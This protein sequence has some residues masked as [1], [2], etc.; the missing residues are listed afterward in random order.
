MK[1]TQPLPVEPAVA[2]TDQLDRHGV[3][4]RVAGELA[5]RELGQLAVVAARQVLAHVAD[6]ARRPGGSCRAAILPPG[7][8]T[9]P[10]GRPRPARGRPRAARARCPRSGGTRPARCGR[11]WDRWSG[12]PPA[13][14]P[15]PRAARCSSSSS[16]SGF[17]GVRRRR[18][19]R[20][21]ISESKAELTRPTRDRAGL[22]PRA[23]TRRRRR[24]RRPAGPGGPPSGPPLPRAG[25]RVLRPRA[26]DPNGAALGSGSWNRRLP[27]VGAPRP[28]APRP[29]APPG[30]TG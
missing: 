15:A 20:R 12:A 8:R 6:L 19:R 11:A 16:R 4:A 26:C 24:R 18:R 9:R 5:R 29:A 2:V 10:G 21:R 1:R 25:R 3:D 28:G 13:P 22:A 30:R 27:V 14:W 23:E 7:S 17:S